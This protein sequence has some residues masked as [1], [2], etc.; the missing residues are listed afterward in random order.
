MSTLPSAISST[1]ATS[2]TTPTAT[3]PLAGMSTGDF[4]KIM[5]S[6]LQNQDPTQPESSSQLLGELS[7]LENVQSQVGLQS[8]L[9][10]MVTQ[11]QLAQAGGLIGREVAGVDANNNQVQGLVTSV[12]V[13]NG[14]PSLQLDTGDS[15]NMS[16]VTAIGPA[17]AANTT[18]TTG[19]TGTPGTPGTIATTTTP[20]TTPAVS[21]AITPASNSVLPALSTTSTTGL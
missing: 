20:T 17:P 9:Q 16:N 1:V 8:G 12:I 11:N 6:E 18:G 15:I 7:S 21:T 3:N 4:L 13:Q 14:T 19:T 10:S 2:A 5:M